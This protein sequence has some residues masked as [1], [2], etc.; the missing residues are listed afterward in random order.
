MLG[1][2]VAEFDA[3]IVDFT[4]CSPRLGSIILP[5]EGIIDTGANRVCLPRRLATQAGLRELGKLKLRTASHNVERVLFE[6]HLNFKSLGFKQ[7]T[8]VVCPEVDGDN[9]PILIGMSVLRQFNIWYHGGLETW[10]FYR[11]EGA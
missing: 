8:Q 2:F 3:P 6:A 7:I 5:V 1:T 9:V 10:S 11:R 4:I